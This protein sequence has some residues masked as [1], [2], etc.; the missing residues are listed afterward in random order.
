MIC[1][2]RPFPGT[3]HAVHGC[4]HIYIYIYM[5]CRDRRHKGVRK[6][7]ALR[8]C[9]S[10]GGHV[11]GGYALTRV[12]PHPMVDDTSHPLSI[13]LSITLSIY[14]STYLSL[15]LCIYLSRY[16]TSSIYLSI[17]HSIIYI[18]ISG[19]DIFVPDRFKRC[20]EYVEREIH[21]PFIPPR[22]YCCFCMFL[23]LYIYSYSSDASFYRCFRHVPIHSHVSIFF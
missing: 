20:K 6:K 4:V 19:Y 9:V 23:S 7:G 21:N 2:S 11:G 14:L 12:P 10:R 18:Y 1:A 22:R 16:I 13:D 3:T 8:G 15:Y 17:Y 5:L